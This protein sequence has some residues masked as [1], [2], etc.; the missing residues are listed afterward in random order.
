MDGTLIFE[1]TSKGI[2]QLA[3]SGSTLPATSREALKL[4]DG[5]RSAQGIA[6]KLG[7]ADVATLFTPLIENEL[8]QKNLGLSLDDD[9]TVRV[10]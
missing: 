6:A 7:I 1:K 4:V 10:R 9:K 8:V 5:N 2:A 3:Q